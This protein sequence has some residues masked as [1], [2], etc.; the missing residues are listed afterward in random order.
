MRIDH[1]TQA[2]VP[3]VRA[4][5]KL[6]FSESDRF[7][8]NF[9][10]AAFAPERCLCAWEGAEL[11]GMLHWMGASRETDRYGYLYAVATHPDHRGKGVCR[12]L[13]AACHE[14]LAKQGCAGA[15]LYPQDDGV[16]QMYAGMGYRNIGGVDLLKVTAGDVPAGIRTVTEEEYCRLRKTFLPE[17]GVIQEGET[18]RLLAREATLYAGKDFVLAGMRLPS[19]FFGAELLGNRDAAAGILAALN[20]EEGVFRVPGEQF[21]FAMFLPL[22]KN[23][24]VPSYLGIVLD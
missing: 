9:F 12:R 2:E 4:L 5:W 23:A 7:L 16:R 13:M 19:G 1:P 17:G 15:L 11:A 20:A 14:L 24:A 18:A 10:A 22:Q 6:V 3:Q 21:P 8:D